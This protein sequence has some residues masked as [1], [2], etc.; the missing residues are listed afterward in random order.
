MELDSSVVLTV[1]R[2]VD[3]VSALSP[4]DFAA[5]VLSVMPSEAK[6][7]NLGVGRIL[8]DYSTMMLT[9]YVLCDI[10]EDGKETLPDGHVL[11]KYHIEVKSG[12]KSSRMADAV[13]CVMFLLCF[14]FLGNYFKYGFNILFLVISALLII[15]AAY[16]MISSSRRAFGSKESDQIASA[17]IALSE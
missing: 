7:E 3:V 13:Y 2:E 10:F 8:N 14:W 4:D 15:A 1:K 6:S 12:K 16:L 17:L 11:N 9:R 5:K